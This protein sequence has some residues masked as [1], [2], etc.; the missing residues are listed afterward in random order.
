MVEHGDSTNQPPFRGLC[1]DCGTLRELGRR[2]FDSPGSWQVAHRGRVG[3]VMPCYVRDGV[4]KDRCICKAKCANCNAIT[5]H[6]YLRADANPDW[7]ELEVAK[8]N[9]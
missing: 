9:R 8:Q 7:L 5:T 4:P 3:E 1:C 6:A 2:W